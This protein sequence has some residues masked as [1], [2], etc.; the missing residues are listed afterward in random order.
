VVERLRSTYRHTWVANQLLLQRAAPA[1]AAL[2]N[3]S[4]DGRLVG[5]AA[6]VLTV[7][8]DAGARR[9]EVPEV[10][11][12]ARKRRRAL[13]TL[14]AGGWSGAGSSIRRWL[15]PLIRRRQLVAD[16]GGQRIQV[17]WASPAIPNGDP[18][19][20][21]E[22]HGRRLCV[23]SIPAQ[24]V[25]ACRAADSGS[26]PDIRSL[27]DALAAMRAASD[28]DWEAVARIADHSTPPEVSRTASYLRRE[29]GAPIPSGVTS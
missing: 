25:R 5:D 18:P 12:P 26:P 6:L 15:R 9:I 23:S 11:V 24:L 3:E 16:G 7:Y 29:V 1:L 13:R 17:S 14:R 20:F 4:L 22:V 10:S 2:G 8:G 19:C 21:V 28:A 27:A